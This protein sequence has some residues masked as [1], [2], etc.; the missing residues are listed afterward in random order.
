ME[1][2][3]Y[4]SALGFFFAAGIFAGVLLLWRHFGR[5]RK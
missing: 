1:A 2:I 5:N 4:L 3:I